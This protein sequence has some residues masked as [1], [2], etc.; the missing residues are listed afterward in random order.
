M[1]AGA[2]TFVGFGFPVA[3]GAGIYFCISGVWQSILPV[4]IGLYLVLYFCNRLDKR[5]IRDNLD[6][7]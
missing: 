5:S 6:D 7:H 3:I 4:A 2:R 1:R